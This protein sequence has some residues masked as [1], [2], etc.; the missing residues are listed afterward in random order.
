MY[1]FLTLLVGFCGF[2]LV[3]TLVVLI[4]KWRTVKRVREHSKKQEEDVDT[5]TDSNTSGSEAS[6]APLE[7]EEDAVTASPHP[8]P[9]NIRRK[10]VPV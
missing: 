6:E 10:T 5:D 2:L 1:V 7:E 4:S 9:K 8:T 3:A